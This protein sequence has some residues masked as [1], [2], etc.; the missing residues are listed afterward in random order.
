MLERYKLVK[1]TRKSPLIDRTLQDERRVPRELPFKW[2]ERP[3]G[4]K[5]EEAAATETDID[6]AKIDS[7]EAKMGTGEN[8]AKHEGKDNV[9]ISSKDKPKLFIKAKKSHWFGS[10]FLEMQ[11]DPSSYSKGLIT[12]EEQAKKEPDFIGDAFYYNLTEPSVRGFH[13]ARDPR[14]TLC[15]SSQTSQESMSC[16]TLA[17]QVLS[18]I[19]ILSLPRYPLAWR[20]GSSSLPSHLRAVP[21]SAELFNK[22]SE[23]ATGEQAPLCSKECIACFAARDLEIMSPASTAIA[24]TSR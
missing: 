11:Q 4:R 19:N 18:S 17:L 2:E 23:R 3:R 8:M 9:K 12:Y 16:C 1:G 7:N 21:A 22:P 20:T 10:D 14:L 15:S 6:K 5:P 24:L 13:L